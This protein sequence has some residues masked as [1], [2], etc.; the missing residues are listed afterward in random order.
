[1][2]ALMKMILMEIM[3]TEFGLILMH[4]TNQSVWLTDIIP[5]S[6]AHRMD[7]FNIHYF[8]SNILLNVK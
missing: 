2:S 1:M 8:L 7:G 4:S 6:F 5:K 3:T